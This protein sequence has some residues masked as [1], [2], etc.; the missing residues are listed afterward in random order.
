MKLWNLHIIFLILF[1][2][3]FLFQAETTRSQ[4][5]EESISIGDEAFKEGDY[6]SASTF[7]NNALWHDSSDLKLAYK[8][9]EA[10]RFFNNYQQAR[11]WYNYV[12]NADSK[13][14]LP[15]SQFYL[16]LME[17]SLGNY[18]EAL[19]QFRA[20]YNE[21]INKADE[22]FIEKARNEIIA[23][24]DAP[25]IIADKKNVVIQ[26]LAET[27]VNTEFSEFN[28]VQLSDT[29]LVFSALKP[30]S[31]GSFDAYIPNAYISKIYMA[32]ATVSGWDKAIELDAK[33][34]DKATHNANICFSKDHKK[35]FFTRA[36]AE[37]NNSLKAEIYVSE[38][39][40]GKWQ[41]AK[42]LSE[43][44]NLEGYTS[45][46]PCFVET[47]DY[48]ML[49]FVSNR[50]GGIGGLDIWYCLVK[51][52]VF[53]DPVNLG[54]LINT[55]GDEI[56]P[57]YFDS[58]QMLYFSSDYHKG[59]GGFDVFYSQG[60]FNTW[61]LPLNI[62][63]PINSSCND[64]YF[65]VTEVDN[66]GYFT[67]NRPGSLSIKSETCCYDIYS[68]EWQDTVK[69]KP[70]VIVPVD[71]PKDTVIIE[72]P[73]KPTLPLTLYFHNDEP[74]PRS[75]DTTT[76]QNYQDLL[77]SY[78]AMKGNY[79]EE[80]SGGLSGHEKSKAEKD[81]H[82]FFE[83]Y[84]AKGFT[85]LELFAKMLQNDLSRGNSIK[86][87]I[88]GFCSPLHTSNYN[89]RLSKRRIASVVNFL[90]EYQ[91]GALL[92]YL[93][94]TARNGAKLTI[95]RDPLGKSTASLLVSD[96][97][98]DQ[99]NSVYS[100]AAAFERKVQIILYESDHQ[101]LPAAG[102]FPDILFTEK[103]FDFGSVTQ[104]SETAITIKFKNTG[105]APLTIAGIETSCSCITADRPIEALAPGKEGS[106]KLS[107]NTSEDAGKY[108]ETITIY[109]N[110]PKAKYIIPV[111][112]V[113]LPKN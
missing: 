40:D 54:S 108:K 63:Y 22:F 35:V 62:G 94:G 105:K 98:N 107:F 4:N 72:E 23:C 8:C 11:R 12:F 28:A 2:G 48:N 3:L 71:I 50:P 61:S 6:Y 41:K 33:I 73:I 27:S 90:K 75:N 76:K 99:R 109:T 49:Y 7:Y 43:K 1:G 96:N 18:T 30:V 81:I 95:I 17:K 38:L 88:K 36:K 106:M 59:L 34:N 57:F 52:G 101:G 5:Y 102:N 20:Y 24:Q 31:Q 44:I 113:L 55:P 51:D 89:Y 111:H 32:R 19:L 53:Q 92:E 13:K 104:G 103:V 69:P 112:A 39:T 26:H 25:K 42:K 110:T 68:Y 70:V 87:K 56:T 91:S 58:T 86:I 78:Y 66:D 83:N 77:N 64:T 80:Y 100:R 15:L 93:N 84:V 46:H 9:A 74:D 82:D 47:S 10:N 60:H 79:T 45:T 21:N 29:A 97:P 65:T 85:Q 67:S 37:D 14:E 16:G